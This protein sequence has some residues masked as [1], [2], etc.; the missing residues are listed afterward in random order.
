M[1]N[2]GKTDMFTRTV[3]TG[4]LTNSV[5]FLCCVSLNFACFAENTIKKGFQQNKQKQ[6]KNM[7]CS[8]LVQGC[9]KS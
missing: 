5:Y 7:L 8:K 3:S 2:A 4:V 6:T 9:V 1:K